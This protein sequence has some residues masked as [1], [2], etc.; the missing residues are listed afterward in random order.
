[1]NIGRQAALRAGLPTSVPGQS[2]D[3][4]CSSGLMAIA[5]AAKQIVHDGMDIAV[6]GGR[7]VDLARPERAHE[8]PPHRRSRAARGARRA[9][10]SR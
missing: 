10:T 2:L 8:P 9:S 6:G 1:M 3:R 7:R 5:T 4:Q